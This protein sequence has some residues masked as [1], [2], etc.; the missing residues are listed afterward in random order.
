MIRTTPMTSSAWA[1]S[2]TRRSSCCGRVSAVDSTP[3]SP[4]GPGPARRRCSTGSR[5]VTHVTEVVGMEGAVVTLQDVFA[6]DYTAGIGDDGRHR[7]SL[8]P[9]GIRPAFA[10]RLADL[11][12]TLAAGTF[13]TPDILTAGRRR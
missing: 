13:G 9:T 8:G 4:A 2:P 11:G 12:V 6:F 10:D 5:R 7:G 3:S 1:R